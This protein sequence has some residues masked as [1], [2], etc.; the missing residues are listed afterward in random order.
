MGLGG[1]G[2]KR[3]SVIDEE[4]AEIE[5]VGDRFCYGDGAENVSKTP[6]L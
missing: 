2:R 1:I 6:A 4:V 3:I 5:S